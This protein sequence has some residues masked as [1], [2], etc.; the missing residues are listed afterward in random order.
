MAH[1]LCVGILTGPMN[2]LGEEE[3]GLCSAPVD[4]DGQ[5]L[6]GDL[7]SAGFQDGPVL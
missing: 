5:R 1:L 7:S 6:P 3:N 4:I 2:E